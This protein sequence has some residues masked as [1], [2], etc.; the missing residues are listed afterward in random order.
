MDCARKI[1]QL[2]DLSI[3]TCSLLILSELYPHPD[4]TFL[5]K[6]IVTYVNNLNYHRE[7]IGIVTLCFF[8]P[9]KPNDPVQ[10]YFNTVVSL[11]RWY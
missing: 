8:F 2:G 10:F 9:L 6:P 1:R 4:S 3:L 5:Y 11:D 7:L